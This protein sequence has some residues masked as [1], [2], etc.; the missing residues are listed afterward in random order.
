METTPSRLSGGNGSSADVFGD[1]RT[2]YDNAQGGNDILDGSSGNQ[3]LYGDAQFYLPSSP[4]S[5]TGGK[6]VLIGGPND[7]LWGGPND[8]T[9][10]FKVASGNDVIQDF[11]QGNLA[12]GSTAPEHDIINVHAYGFTDWS[13]LL[14]VIS[15]D[16][17]GD[18]VVQLSPTDSITLTGVHTAN[19]HASDFIV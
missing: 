3:V 14:A 17:A 7:Q 11:N 5:I 16:S 18:A 12:V 4:G 10:K 13:A 15:D 19:L 1:A 6:D 9:F 8:D 2:L